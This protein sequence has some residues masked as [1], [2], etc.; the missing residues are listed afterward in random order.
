MR[1]V[2][3]LVKFYVKS[4]TTSWH[5]FWFYILVSTG[6]VLRCFCTWV[7]A[8]EPRACCI[9]V[10]SFVTNFNSRFTLHWRFRRA[11]DM[12]TRVG[13]GWAASPHSRGN[14][15]FRRCCR[16]PERARQ[17]AGDEHKVTWHSGRRRDLGDFDW[18]VFDA[19]ADHRPVVAP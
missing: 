1:V 13:Q 6:S 10:N 9:S 5:N 7:S 15:Q 11:S 3:W 17:A 4:R 8:F 14:F 12:A 16:R 19:R 2:K 18:T